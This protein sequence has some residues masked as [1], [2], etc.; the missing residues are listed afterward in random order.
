MRIA[1]SPRL[2]TRIF[3][4]T[5]TALILAVDGPG[6]SRRNPLGPRGPTHGN[7]VFAIAI[8]G[9]PFGPPAARIS[10]RKRLRL[11]ETLDRQRECFAPLGIGLGSRD[12]LHAVE[13]KG[14]RDS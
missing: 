12:E 7:L 1:I 4:N 11:E 5:A 3:E 6:P 13:P 9:D 8:L 14:A 10:R 2:A